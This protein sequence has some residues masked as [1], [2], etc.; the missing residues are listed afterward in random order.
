MNE[1]N[2]CMNEG[3]ECMNEGVNVASPASASSCTNN[4]LLKELLCW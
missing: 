3:N 2:E 1:G 4:L